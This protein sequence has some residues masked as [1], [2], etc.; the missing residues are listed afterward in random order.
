MAVRTHLA[1]IGI[2]LLACSPF[3]YA[4]QSLPGIYKGSY[5]VVI[6]G[7]RSINVG[8]SLEILTAADG[9]ITGKMIHNGGQ[10]RG[11]Y[12]A[13]GTYEGAKLDIKVAEGVVRGCGNYPLIVTAEGSKLVGTLDGKKIELSR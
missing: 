7:G 3:S 10:C 11:E 1:G 8:V 9:K 6:S 13:A 5:D 12:T 4:Q 2:A